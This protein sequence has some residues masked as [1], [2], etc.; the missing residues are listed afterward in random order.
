VSWGK[1]KDRGDGNIPAL[2]NYRLERGTLE[3]V[4]ES[5]PHIRQQRA[6]VHHLWAEWAT[7]TSLVGWGGG[8]EREAEAG[9]CLSSD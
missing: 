4:L 8:G 3:S 9:A 5:V 2:A 1:S 7:L 6:D